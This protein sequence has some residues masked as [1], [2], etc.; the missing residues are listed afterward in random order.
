MAQPRVRDV[1]TVVEDRLEPDPRRQ[2]MLLQNLL[3]AARSIG[4]ESGALLDQCFP[5]SVSLRRIS[6][7]MR[8][9]CLPRRRLVR[10]S[11]V[12]VEH[13]HVASAYERSTVSFTGLVAGPSGPRSIDMAYERVIR[14]AL[15]LIEGQLPDWHGRRGFSKPIQH[16][17]EGIAHR[18]T[19]L[20]AGGKCQ[21]VIRMP[22]KPVMVD[23]L[24]DS[25]S[26]LAIVG[27]RKGD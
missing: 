16:D 21:R 5:S 20:A 25:L 13:D 4:C 10:P 7:H 19:R 17:P 9:Q 14:A 12:D 6:D 18:T 27:R 11:R 15:L 26:E 1:A 8:S 3:I 2:Q 24:L 22:I 23:K